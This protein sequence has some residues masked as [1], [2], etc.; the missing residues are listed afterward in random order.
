MTSPTRAQRPPAE[1][2]YADELAELARRDSGPV[3]P[4]WKLSMRAA[5]QFIAGGGVGGPSRGG[6]IVAVQHEVEV[7]GVVGPREGGVIPRDVVDVLVA[8][9]PVGLDTGGVQD[10]VGVGEE[11]LD[12]VCRAGRGEPA[13]IPGQGNADEFG[14]EG[15]DP[16]HLQASKGEGVA[17]TSTSYSHGAHHIRYGNV[18]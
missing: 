15:S 10:T 13:H 7:K 16:G 1:A 5:I 8:D 14:G 9:N 18:A 6:T 2:L 11:G 3:P 4:G 17:F 12:V